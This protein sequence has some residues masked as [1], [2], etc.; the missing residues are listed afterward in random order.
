MREIA[1]YQKAHG[2]FSA[3]PDSDWVSPFLTCY[4]VFALVKARQAGYDINPEILDLAARYLTD[5]V[6]SKKIQG[7]QPLS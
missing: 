1:S 6:R 7:G 3:W 4:A 5:F 2:G